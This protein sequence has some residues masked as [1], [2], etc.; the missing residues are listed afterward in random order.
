[1][2][3]K[4]NDW[5]RSWWVTVVVHSSAVET[6]MAR[7][8]GKVQNRSQSDEGRLTA[9]AG[10]WQSM[11]LAAEVALDAIGRLV[12]CDNNVYHYVQI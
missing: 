1:M 8:I 10:C 7:V 12:Q 5:F 3:L 9:V 2:G 11:K 6:L 4:E